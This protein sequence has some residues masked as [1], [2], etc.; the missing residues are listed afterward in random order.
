MGQVHLHNRSFNK[1]TSA[2]FLI[3]LGIVYGD[4]GTSPLYAMQAIVR[5]QGG[6]ANLSESFIL[7]AVSLVIWTL[8]LITT[9]KYVLIA[10]KADNH[11]EG[12]S[13]HSS[14]L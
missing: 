5:G 9:V 2:G 4:I 11:H 10:L 8:T 3:A 14:P 1:A 7:G 12:G 13:F 6:L